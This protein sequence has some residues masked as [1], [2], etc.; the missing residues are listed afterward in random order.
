MKKKNQTELGEPHCG[1]C[2]VPV[3]DWLAHVGT[4]EHQRRVNDPLFIQRKMIESQLGIVRRMDFSAL[5]KAQ[6]PKSNAQRP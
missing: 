1:L 6:R 5:P 3:A 2:N 4:P